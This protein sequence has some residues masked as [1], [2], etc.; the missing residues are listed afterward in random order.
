MITELDIFLH[1]TSFK[2]SL[3]KSVSEMWDLVGLGQKTFLQLSFR[4]IQTEKSGQM[5]QKK[6]NQ[7]FWLFWMHRHGFD[8][9]FYTLQTHSRSIMLKVTKVVDINISSLL[10]TLFLYKKRETTYSHLQKSSLPFYCSKISR[11]QNRQLKYVHLFSPIW[12]PDTEGLKFQRRN[13]NHSCV[14]GW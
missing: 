1:W 3:K 4:C 2:I 7:Y 11:M 5:G 9:W 6:R 14:I 8:C 12:N 10:H 13:R